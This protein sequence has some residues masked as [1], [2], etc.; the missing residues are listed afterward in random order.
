M[1]LSNYILF[2]LEY[3]TFIFKVLVDKSFQDLTS[4]SGGGQRIQLILHMKDSKTR[5]NTATS[6]L[7]SSN[8][9][10]ITMLI[11]LPDA[12]KDRLLREFGRLQKYLKV[13]MED[14]DQGRGT[15]R[16]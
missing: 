11:V 1:Y 3:K 15:G 2:V 10:R 16:D 13:L 9:L 14:R 5:M 7:A 12:V 4:Y 8:C 6:V